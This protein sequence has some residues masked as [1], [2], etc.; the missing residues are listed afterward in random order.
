MTWNMC[1]LVL[2]LHWPCKNGNWHSWV[3]RSWENRDVGGSLMVSAFSPGVGALNI[4]KLSGGVGAALLR[5]RDTL[6]CR[7]APSLVHACIHVHYCYGGFHPYSRISQDLGWFFF[8]WMSMCMLTTSV[9]ML[10]SGRDLLN[11]LCFFHGA[12][13]TG[14]CS[15]CLA[16]G[17]AGSWPGSVPSLGNAHIHGEW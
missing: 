13:C 11:H 14:S 2:R 15:L 3:D 12:A 4:V 8:L 10:A 7:H 9:S 6:A 1:S 17:R 16:R 5:C